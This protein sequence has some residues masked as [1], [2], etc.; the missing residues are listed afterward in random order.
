MNSPL[1]LYRTILKLHR[2]LPKGNFDFFKQKELQ[3]IGDGYVKQEFR[4]HK[5][6]EKEFIGPFLTEW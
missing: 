1:S 5:S 2:K 4:A 3:Q 6:V